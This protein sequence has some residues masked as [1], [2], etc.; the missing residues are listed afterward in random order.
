MTDFY[1]S[2]LQYLAYTP[3][4]SLSADQRLA[5]ARE[6]SM[7]ALAAEDVYNFGEVVRGSRGGRSEGSPRGERRGTQWPRPLD[8]TGSSHLHTSLLTHSTRAHTHASAHSL[9]H[10]LPPPCSQLATPILSALEGTEDGWLGDLMRAFNAGDVDSFNALLADHRA[11][12]AQHSAMAAGLPTMKQKIALLC[13]VELVFR[14]SA[15]DRTI[16]FAEVADAT[17]MPVAEVEWL[18]MRAM[19]VDL[20]RGS[21]DQVEGVVR[22]SYVQPRVLDDGQ[23]TTLRD[24]L[25]TWRKTVHSMQV[26]VED[27]TRELFS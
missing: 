7:A 23:T 12:V 1:R 27:G 4:E 6:I 14:R 19:A 5:L 18:L 11:A 15:A 24:Q 9:T 22:V 13:L 25:A 8:P 26:M 17:R 10:T 2:S 21:I 20:I 16:T 3:L